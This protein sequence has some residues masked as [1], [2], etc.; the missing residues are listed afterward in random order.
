[1]RRA[2]LAL[3]L[4]LAVC[5]RADS[6][7]VRLFSAAPP[8]EIEILPVRA[9]Y[10]TCSTCKA[11]ALTSPLKLVATANV[12]SFDGKRAPVFLLE[13]RYKLRT[14]GVTTIEF[15][16][17]LEVRSVHD[18]LKPIATL[19]T[20]Q[21]VAMAVGGEAGGMR[22]PEALKAIAV[23]IRTYAVRFRGRH[24][25]DGYDL[26]DSTHCQ[27]LR[28]VES[29][30][31]WRAAADDTASELAWYDGAPIAAY[32]HASC[33]GQLEDGRVML[34]EPVPYL[35]AKAD[36]VCRGTA[37]WDAEIAT[38]DLRRALKDAGFRLGSRDG[39]SISN[40]DTSGRVRQL[41]VSGTSVDATSF[42]MA[43]GR[44]LGWNKVRS[45]IF[46]VTD[47]GSAVVFHGRGRGHGVGLCQ[48][49][50]E[51]RGENGESYRD[52]L[53][54]YYPGTKIGITA[55][56]LRWQRYAGER[57]ELFTT[58]EKDKALLSTA[59]RA[60]RDAER[61]TGWKLRAEPSLRVYPTVAAFRDAT[62]EPG[63][64]AASTRG[65]TVRL[66]PAAVLKQTGA[67]ESTLRH[68]LLHMAVE[69][70]ARA[71]LPLWFR[72]GV[73]LYL[74][75]GAAPSK[76]PRNRQPSAAL[77]NTFEHPRDAASLK[78]AYATAAARVAAM[79]K[80]HGQQAV[81]GWVKEGIPA[82]VLAG[83]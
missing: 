32:H 11:N 80:A 38:S 18:E 39:I 8:V 67:L 23:A 75:G 49:G 52:I 47:E 72:E 14:S 46:D 12:V 35:K 37:E 62:G 41:F 21:Y 3:V 40:R 73:V 5:A 45:E 36:P 76:A 61:A 29:N 56:G 27:V 71:G 83:L 43:I 13:G 7:R 66:Q 30:P 50:A 48:S 68:E 20:E 65:R 24:A 60:L 63:W 69:E 26:C 79:V 55:Q 51:L 28:S 78:A 34:G 6:L 74:S 70:Q 53:A 9:S 59:E 58:Q 77:E 42:R 33:G 44:A 2:T 10:R 17:P 4:L 1:M 64:V 15:D 31:A 16:A 57:M 81:L 82:T 22:S 19:P 54:F 25:R